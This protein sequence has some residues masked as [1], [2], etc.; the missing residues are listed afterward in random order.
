VLSADGGLPWSL[1]LIERFGNRL[2]S[3]RAREGLRRTGALVLNSSAIDE[4]MTH[5][6]HVEHDK[7][8]AV[9][10]GESPC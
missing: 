9:A 1:E 4:I 5:F 6:A 3:D 8:V 2:D 7:T 10:T